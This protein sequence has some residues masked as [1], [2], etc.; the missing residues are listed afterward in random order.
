MCFVTFF[1]VSASA[2]ILNLDIHRPKKLVIETDGEHDVTIRVSQESNFCVVVDDNSEF[3]NETVNIANPGLKPY[4]VSWEDLSAFTNGSMKVSYH[5][6]GG[7]V[8]AGEL[9]EFTSY[10]IVDKIFP[11]TLKAIHFEIGINKR[12][13]YIK[14]TGDERE[15]PDSRGQINP[16]VPEGL[17]NL[18]AAM[19][20]KVVIKTDGERDVTLV[21][22]QIGSPYY[23]Y[24][25]DDNHEFANE[26]VSI[27]NPGVEPFMVVLK[28]PGGMDNCDL[29]VRY[30]FDNGV[31]ISKKLESFSTYT[32]VDNL[33]A[34]VVKN[35]FFKVG[36]QADGVYIECE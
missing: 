5:F 6:D 35:L 7:V 14:K 33:R 11:K 8:V 20:N 22:K 25:A 27:D 13:V 17:L 34:E 21:V 2:D 18:S 15:K 12:G 19:P 24:E 23:Y 9:E 26:T 31:S 28:H 30:Y 4:Q 10:Y 1:S 29:E 3:A 32:V 36:L 16:I